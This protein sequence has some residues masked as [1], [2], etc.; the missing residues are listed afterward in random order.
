VLYANARSSSNP[1]G[2]LRPLFAFRSLVDPLPAFAQYYSP[3]GS[4]TEQ[5][6]GEV[7]T[8]AFTPEADAFAARLLGGARKE[9]EEIYFANM[10]GTPG[11]WRPVYAFPEDWYDFSHAD[12]FH[13]LDIDLGGPDHPDGAYDLI[14][15]SAPLRLSVGG[16]AGGK[17]LDPGTTIRS[18]RMKYM[19]V[20]F[21]RPWLSRL[22]FQSAGWRLKGQP[23]GFC[24]SGEL[25]ANAGILP[26]LPS[27]M[28]LAKDVSLN[29]DWGGTDRELFASATSAGRS[30]SLG[31][32]AL[33]GSQ[34]GAQ[35]IA[36]TSSLTPFS[37]R[38]S[39]LVAGSVLVTNRGA[40]V[41]RFSVDWRR[42]GRA[43]TGQSGNFPVLAAK[44]IA[45]PADATDISVTVE[46]MTAPWPAET[47]RT[48]TTLEFPTPVRKC[49]ELAGETWNVKFA[50]VACPS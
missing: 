14:G 23:A 49:F 4:S 15:G 30:V 13:E 24:S 25:N 44:S 7:L 31:P 12:R 11:K 21:Q 50:E 20:S 5:I 19:L 8:G 18:L 48:V 35:L 10:D 29:A 17:P 1:A 9:F 36:W 2:D 38:D 39:D 40:F 26:L 6:Y 22:M 47:W 34:S 32:F 45:I 3:I 41:C 27:G 33:G 43:S 28:L 37:P 46:V 42:G 16:Q